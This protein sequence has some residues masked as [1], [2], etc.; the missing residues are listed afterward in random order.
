VKNETGVCEGLS[1]DSATHEEI[2]DESYAYAY[3]LQYD[4]L[5]RPPVTFFEYMPHAC[6]LKVKIKTYKDKWRSISF[7]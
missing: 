1:R 7:C 3:I 5:Y 2:M 4:Q 6:I